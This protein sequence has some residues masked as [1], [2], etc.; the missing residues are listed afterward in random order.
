MGTVGRKLVFGVLL[1]LLGGCGPIEY[2]NEVTRKASTEVDSAKAVAN[3]EDA[4][5]RYYFTL[6]IEYLKKARIEASYADYQAA[7]RFGRKASFAAQ[8]ARETALKSAADP[9][10]MVRTPDLDEG[11]DDDGFSDLGGDE[12]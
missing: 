5:Y 7:N 8:K 11:V 3:E 10:S 12:Q 2:V 1:S 4:Y 9:S 6:A